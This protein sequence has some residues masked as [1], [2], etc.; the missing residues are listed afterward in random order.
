MR[1]RWLI[2][3]ALAAPVAGPAPAQTPLSDLD[4]RVTDADVQPSVTIKQ[5]DNR[6]IQRYS[7]NNNTYMIKVTPTVGA[8]YYLVDEDGSGEMAW[9]RGTPGV[10]TTVPQ[11]TLFSW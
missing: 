11:W 1:H 4:L 3:M 6:T 10:E 8:P 9:R 7:V 2:A 5:Y